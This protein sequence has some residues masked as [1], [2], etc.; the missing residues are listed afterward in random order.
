MKLRILPVG[1]LEAN[2]CLAWDEGS[3]KGIILDPGAQ[4]DRIRQAVEKSE[5][6]PEAILLTHGHFDHVA[7]S[8][9][10]REL[11]GI[12]VIIG[13]NELTLL[14]DPELNLSRPYMRKDVQAA[15]D[16]TVQDQEMLPFLG[17]LQ[18]L[19]V[20]G[21]TPG[22]MCYYTASEGVLFSGDTLFQR[23]IGRTDSYEAQDELL[24]HI[25]EKLL[26]LPEDTEVIPGHGPATKIGA[27]KRYNLFLV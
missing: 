10:L 1:P 11:Y 12:P 21:H 8:D 22:S 6:I 2:C 26:V 9:I 5:M 27:E 16:R 13:E 23:S 18:A 3:G 4:P 14:R 7:A 19:E 20:A 15:V 24:R 17:G 25:R